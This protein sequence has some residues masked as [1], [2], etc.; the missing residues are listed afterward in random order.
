MTIKWRSRLV[1]RYTLLH[2]CSLILGV[3]MF[4]SA[5][6]VSAEDHPHHYATVATDSA[7]EPDATHGVAITLDAVDLHSVN[8][9]SEAVTHELWLTPDDKSI[10]V[11][12]GLENGYY[13]T[14]NNSPKVFWADSR[15]GGGFHVHLPNVTANLTTFYQAV[16]WQPNSS[17]TCSW[18][19]WFGNVYLGTSNSNCFSA[20]RQGIAGIES[21]VLSSGSHVQGFTSDQFRFDSNFSW[22]SGWNSKVSA[23]DDPT[24]R[25]K[26]TCCAANGTE[27]TLNHVY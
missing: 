7:N 22:Q 24:I 26:T 16:I 10:W 6:V 12:T 14:C 5:T 11:E 2:D 25:I 8:C 13:G 3:A 18:D 9:S 23:T 17:Y 4:S 27:E 19:V 1:R 20:G 21:T 15:N